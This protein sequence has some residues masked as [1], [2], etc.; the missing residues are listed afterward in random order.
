M[1]K[2]IF[3]DFQGTLAHNDWMFSK[4]LYKVLVKNDANTEISIDDIKKKQMKG[5]PWQ[6]HEKEYIHL[7][8][9]AAWWQNA[10]N[11]FTECYKSLG[12][13]EEKAVGFAKQVR[14]ELIKI[15]E[16]VLYEDTIETL[17]YFKEKGY[18][19]IILSNHIPEL[20]EIVE[21][22]GLCSYIIDCIS[23]ANIGYEKPNPT[24]VQ[25]GPLLLGH[26]G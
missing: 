25:G 24:L 11:I 12:F 14:E 23:S 21:G 16:F 15:D 22:I 3:W 26:A 5:F 9:S 18:D 8:D 19:N 2:I 20:P 17:N 13:V 6:D 10:E 1:D 7:T 4:A